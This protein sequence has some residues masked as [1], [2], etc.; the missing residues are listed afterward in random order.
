MSILLTGGTG[1][2]GSHTAV[3]L[4]NEGYDVVIAD[5]LVNSSRIVV[6]RI[7]QITGKSPVFYDCDVK[8]SEQL[9]RVFEENPIDAVIHFAGLKAV[10]ESVKKPVEYDR[11]NLDTTL[12]LLEQMKN[13]GVKRIVFS[14]SATVYGEEN[15]YPYI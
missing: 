15:P 13:A 7:G 1:Y 12:T 10:G 14:S 4:I 9:A 11:N 3:A 6:D 8:D 5:N 2:I